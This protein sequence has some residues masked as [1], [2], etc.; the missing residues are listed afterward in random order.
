MMRSS[1]DLLIQKIDRFTR[2]F[3]LS[4]ILRGSLYWIGLV[5]SVFLLLALTEFRAFFAP[6]FK[7]PLVS[8]FILIAIASL[9]WWMV[10]PLLSYLKLGN[11]ISHEQVASIIGQHFPDVKDKLLNILQLN[12]DRSDLASA[13]LIEASINQKSEEIKLV[14]FSNAV[15]LGSNKKYLR[16]ALPPALVLLAIFLGSPNILRDSTSRLAKPA[17]HFEKA[18]PFSFIVNPPEKVIQY[19]DAKIEVKLEGQVMPSEVFIERNGKPFKME[20]KQKDAYQYTFKNITEPFEFR[21]QAEGFASIPYNVQIIPKPTLLDAQVELRYPAYT[22]KRPEVLKNVG[23]LTFP[24]GTNATWKFN[25]K[26]TSDMQVERAEKAHSLDNQNGFFTYESRIFKNEA[27]RF[28]LSND[29]LNHADSVEYRTNVIADQYP[30]ITAEKISDSADASYMYFIGEYA[31]DYGVSDLRFHFKL[32]RFDRNKADSLGS[33]RLQFERNASL[34][35]FSHFTNADL[36]TLNPG[37]QLEY[38]FEVLDNDGVNGAKSARSR[39]FTYKKPTIQEFKDQ[40]DENNEEIKDDLADAIDKVEDFSKEVQE[41]KEDVLEKKALSWEEKKKLEDLMSQHDDLQK[42]LEQMQQNFQENLENQEEFKEIA[43]EILEKQERVQELMEELMTDEMK[44]MM[45]QLRQMMDEMEMDEMFQ[46]LEDFEFSNEELE[47]Q[48]DRMLE[49]FKKLEFEQAMQDMANELEELAEEQ[50]DLSEESQQDDANSEDILE[51]QEEINEK[52]DELKEDFSELEEMNQE[53]QSPTDL[54]DLGEKSEEVSE[55]MEK[56]TEQLEKQQPS[57][58]SPSQQKAGEKMKEMAQQMQGMMSN[59]MQMQATEDLEDLRQLLENLVKFS[60]DQE[61]LFEEVKK[62]QTD[63]PKFRELVQQQYKLKDDAAM[64]EDSLISLSKRVFQLES[65]ITEELHKM[66]REIGQSIDNMVERRKGPA[67]GNQ[68]YVMT[69]ANNLALML[70]ET[71]EQMQQAM[72]Q[73]M[74]GNQQCQKPGGKGKLPSMQQMQQQ[75]NKDMQEMMNG[76]K[77]GK[78]GGGQEMSKEFAR[79]AQEQAALREALRKMKESMSQSEK[80]GG[81]VDEVLEQMD[82]TETELLNKQITEETL[83]RQQEIITNLL[84][85]ETA[86]K[87][88]D[89]EEK[90][91]SQTATQVNRKL[92]P[93]I[94]KYLKERQSTV[95]VYQ[96]V[97]PTLS[98]FYKK[99]VEKYFQGV[100]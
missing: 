70:S 93:E 69:S 92:P 78:Q 40:E 62:T 49:L 28:Y 67:V 36:F 45:E 85:M 31:D 10:R 81:N 53:Q 26:Q 76:M 13:E 90:R 64:I 77:K 24:V 17:K 25:A 66:N 39:V 4:Q 91:E 9:S 96:S 15:D 16:Y 54:D 8:A 80:S 46:N 20:A 73:S 7:I 52:F 33:E 58:A 11:R 5:L 75:L 2:K 87:E 57:K 6:E 51:K 47:N 63:Q 84:D 99:L 35:R 98:P 41:L 79:M 71:M 37:D 42:A 68:Q 60:F 29:A 72:A 88:Q 44:E 55:E 21:V 100:N 12:H 74:P 27:L 18:A 14:P 50:M 83:K 3:Y 34:G 65:F 1:Y 61:G 89:K 86:E 97:P 59:M 38:F 19:E 56:G 94:E 22:G 43:P 30:S 32:N 23:E 82:Q 48:L 95:E